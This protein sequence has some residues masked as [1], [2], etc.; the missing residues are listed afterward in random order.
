MERFKKILKK[1]FFLKPLPTVLVAVPSLVLVFAVLGSGQTETVLAYVSYVLSAY[2]FTVLIIG[3]PGILDALKNGFWNLRLI[4]KI[5][6]TSLGKCFLDSMVFR[7]EVTLHRRLLVNLLY[8]MLKLVT[9]ILYRSVCLIGLAVYY[10]LLAIMRSILVHDLHK[11]KIGENMQAEFR[12]YRTCGVLLV[13]MNQALAGIVYYVVHRNQ[14]FSYPGYLIYGMALYAFYSIIST[15]IH[16]IKFRKI[17]SPLLSA[18]K[19]VDLTAACVSMM[20]LETAMLAA[21][22][23]DDPVFRKYMTGISGACVCTFVL[24]MAVY[25]I[26]RSGKYLKNI[27]G[28]KENEQK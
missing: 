9:G 21:F 26:G 27:S 25:M 17:G 3:F 19:V 6:S 16:V 15:T 5:Q 2:A 20:S 14:G 8:V 22:G 13:F 23:G 10:I 4:R 28:E 7:S 24:G 1:L 11:H 18:A 12:S